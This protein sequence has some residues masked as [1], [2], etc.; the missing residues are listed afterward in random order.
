[1]NESDE[2]VSTLVVEQSQNGN[3]AEPACTASMVAA[4]LLFARHD[5]LAPVLAARHM[6][7]DLLADQEHLPP[8][9]ASLLQDLRAACDRSVVIIDEHCQVTDGRFQP[10]FDARLKSLRHDLNNLLG[11]VLQYP[12]LLLADDAQTYGRFCRE[13]AVIDECCQR[14]G[15]RLKNLSPKRVGAT[16]CN[17]AVLDTADIGHSSGDRAAVSVD[18]RDKCRPGRVLLVEDETN[19]RNSLTRSL[20]D[21]GHEVFSAIDGK[22]ALRL[23]DAAD[24]E[25]IDV[26]LLDVNLGESNGCQILK[27]LKRRT[28]MTH[29]PVVMVS[30]TEEREVMG[31]CIAAGADDFL[32]KP[33]DDVLLMSRLQNALARVRQHREFLNVKSRLRRRTQQRDDILRSLFPKK[34]VLELIGQKEIPPRRYSELAV[35]FCDIV[36][37]TSF[38]D[39]NQD[40]PHVVVDKLRRMFERFEASSEAHRVEKIK[41][42]GDCFMGACWAE[43]VAN[44]VES[45]IRCAVEMLEAAAD[46]QWKLRIGIHYGT[47]VAGKVGNRQYCFDLWG[48]AVNTAARVQAAANIDSITLS[49]AAFECVEATCR[50]LDRGFVF[51]NGKEE[52]IRMYE[53][54]DFWRQ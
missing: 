37:F 3:G 47:V 16:F 12:A 43:D 17:P 25:S 15:R 1:M 50:A 29:V 10:E 41:T 40:E 20:A 19:A 33:V 5:L 34:V 32:I 18:V 48:D 49:E 31:Q 21:M 45:C 6:V 2:S 24:R 35:M 22:D 42:I 38:C 44:N 36:G 11:V 7:A 13:L 39:K 54:R 27:D 4:F 8:E 51:V 9:F 53:F 23:A 52:P 26:V 46:E 30:G 14:F 28:W